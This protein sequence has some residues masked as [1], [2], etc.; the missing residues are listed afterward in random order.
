MISRFVGFGTEVK[1]CSLLTSFTL[2]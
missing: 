2:H 1:F